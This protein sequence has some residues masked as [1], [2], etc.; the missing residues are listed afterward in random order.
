M[1]LHA[2][3]SLVRA[4]IFLQRR[5]A[6]AYTAASAVAGLLACM[7]NPAVRSLGVSLVMCVLIGQ[8]FHLPIVSVLQDAVRGSRAFTLSL[9]VTPCEYAA[10]KIAACALLFLAPAVSAAVAVLAVP[11][12]DRLFSL[13]MVLLALL[14]GLIF[15][16]QSLGIALVS[17]SMGVS[18]TFLVGQLFILGNGIPRFGSR[19]P[20][21]LQFWGQLHDG[22][23]L[24]VAAFAVFAVELAAT[25][26]VVLFLMSRKRR[27][28]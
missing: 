7:P 6:L 15:F 25:V 26:A 28:V 5:A 1:N 4:E 14:G 22:G 24:R 2:V 23:P 18:M 19:I 9:P 11:G 20:G 3:L 12:P 10:G 13:P 16:V 8:C 21:A 27:F 17:E